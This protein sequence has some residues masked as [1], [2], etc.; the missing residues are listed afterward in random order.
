M[1]SDPARTRRLRTSRERAL[2]MVLA[3]F[4][5]ALIIAAVLA[6]THVS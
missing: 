2:A 6:L 5:A 3:A 1:P 4:V